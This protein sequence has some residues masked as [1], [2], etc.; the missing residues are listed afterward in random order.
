MFK[1]KIYIQA[2]SLCFCFSF[3]NWPCH[4]LF[5]NHSCGGNRLFKGFCFYLGKVLLGYYVGG[6]L[7]ILG[8]SETI[9]KPVQKKWLPLL[10]SWLLLSIHLL[11]WKFNLLAATAGLAIGFY[12]I[13]GKSTCTIWKSGNRELVSNCLQVIAIK[14]LSKPSQTHYALALGPKDIHINTNIHIPSPSVTQSP[15]SQGQLKS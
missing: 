15:W 7:S 6:N 12:K 10:G 13:P 14:L 9:R 1:Q 2:N 4:L 5:V 8:G 11:P 3:V